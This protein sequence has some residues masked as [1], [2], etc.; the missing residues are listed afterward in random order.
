MFVEVV[1]AKI[2]KKVV[3]YAKNTIFINCFDNFLNDF[4]NDFFLRFSS[5]KKII[6]NFSNY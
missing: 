2:I 5:F 4:L 3:N 6:F 1:N